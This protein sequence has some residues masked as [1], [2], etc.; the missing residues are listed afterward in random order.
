MWPSLTA[1]SPPHLAHA[2]YDLQVHSRGRFPS[3][4]GSQIKPHIER[5]YGAEWGKP[6]KRMAESVAAVK[7]SSAVGKVRSL[8]LPREFYTHTLMPPNFNPGPNPYGPPPILLGALGPIMTRTA[9]EV[10]DGLLVMPFQHPA[11]T[12][13]TI[14]ALTAGLDRSGRRIDDFR[15]SPR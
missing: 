3:R 9:G 1:R 15:S 10:A 8:G 14:P 4:P 11:F 6:A 12:E 7:R 5:R 2:A 13:R